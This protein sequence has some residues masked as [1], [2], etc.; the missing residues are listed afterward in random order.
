[1]FAYTVYDRKDDYRE[2]FFS[3]EE[4]LAAAINH[5]ITE[6][7]FVQTIFTEIDD[8]DSFTITY[9]DPDDGNPEE[10]TIYKVSF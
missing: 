2:G 10:I 1:M 3:K 4:A 9:I 5:C 7:L 6:G 8:E